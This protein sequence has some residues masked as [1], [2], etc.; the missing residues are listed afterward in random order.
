[1]FLIFPL[2]LLSSLFL[3]AATLLSYLTLL[4]LYR[5]CLHPLSKFPGPALAGYTYW[6]EF[7]YDLIAGPFPG[8]GIYN[9]ERLHKRYGNLVPLL[10]NNI[11]IITIRT[12][13]SR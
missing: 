8:Q 13:R 9:I 11:P 3:I 2:T 7:Y 1:M 10:Q 12:N 6:Y 4:S 5:L